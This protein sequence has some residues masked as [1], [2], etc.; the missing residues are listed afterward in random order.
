MS[1]RHKLDSSGSKYEKCADLLVGQIANMVKVPREGDFGVDFYCEPRFPV[2]S[3]T[4][5]VAELAALQVKG[6]TSG[7]KFGG[8]NRKGEWKDYEI[9]KLRALIAPLYLASVNKSCTAVELFSLCPLWSILWKAGHPFEMICTSQPASAAPYHLQ[10]PRPS[11]HARGAGKGDGMRWTVDLGPPFLRLTSENM[12]DAVFK[13]RAVAVLRSWIVRDRL[14][15][16]YTQLGVPVVPSFTHWNTEPPEILG[17]GLNYLANPHPGMNIIQVS[18]A[19]APILT[20][21]VFNLKLQNDEAAY[22]FLPVLAWLADR[23][24]LDG[25]GQGLLRDLQH[26]RSSSLLPRGDT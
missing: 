11:P 14:A 5:T 20:S 25:L 22:V 10:E 2:N 6:N 21:L 1:R 15:L 9:A 13:A 8:L 7:L 23:G 12:N 24:H 18:Q 3:E 16:I 19:V 26:A 17:E 4:E